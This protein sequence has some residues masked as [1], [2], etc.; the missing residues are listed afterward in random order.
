ME[1]IAIFYNSYQS[2][3]SALEKISGV[4]EEEPSVPEPQSPVEFDS[5]KGHIHFNGVEF[6]YSTGP[7][8]LHKFDL[9]IPAG[10]DH[11]SGWNDRGWKVHT[12]QADL[13]FL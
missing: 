10:S 9:E 2:A 8:V 11:C 3:A 12:C 1:E 5:A 6:K 4:L 7:T 13:S